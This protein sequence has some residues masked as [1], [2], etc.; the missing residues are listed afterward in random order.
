MG[1]KSKRQKLEDTAPILFLELKVQKTKKAQNTKIK[2]NKR[3]GRSWCK[4]YTYDT[5]M[6]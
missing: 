6:P 5:H 4:S 3:V 1:E 2:N